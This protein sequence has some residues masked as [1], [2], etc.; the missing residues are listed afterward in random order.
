MSKR[1]RPLMGDVLMT[2]ADEG[3]LTD[4]DINRAAEQLA[5]EK[6]DTAWYIQGVMG[7]GGWMA[8]GFLFISA[9]WLLEPF[10][11]IPML[12]FIMGLLIAGVTSVIRRVVDNLAINQF[13]LVYHIVAQVIVLFALLEFTGWG[14][15]NNAWPFSTLRR[16][17]R[18]ALQSH[19]W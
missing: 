6:Q 8:A 14:N 13:M 9:V 18:V 16:L 7:C 19:L 3:Y 4:D 11:D 5:A 15:S 12:A 17:R 1:N 2:L 10:L